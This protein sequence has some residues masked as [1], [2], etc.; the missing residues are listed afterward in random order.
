MLASDNMKIIATILILCFLSGRQLLDPWNVDTGLILDRDISGSILMLSL[1]VTDHLRPCLIASSSRS[2]LSVTC[3]VFAVL[4]TW[5]NIFQLYLTSIYLIYLITFFVFHALT[6]I[7][8]SVRESSH[9]TIYSSTYDEGMVIIMLTL[10]IH[11]SPQMR[12]L[13]LK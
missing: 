13:G 11:H 1:Q 8:L 10:H 12:K 6:R 4:I 7:Q 2:F 9:I 5:C 3:V